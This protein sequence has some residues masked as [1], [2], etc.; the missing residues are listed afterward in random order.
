MKTSDGATPT[1]KDYLH[2]VGQIINS[3][4]MIDGRMFDLFDIVLGTTSEK[5]AV[6]FYRIGGF[7]QRLHLVDR[8]AEMS[9]S[10]KDYVTWSE[11]RINLAQPVITR[12]LVAHSPVR[13]THEAQATWLDLDDP[14]GYLIEPATYAISR[15]DKELLDPERQPDVRDLEQLNKHIDATVGQLQSLV[16][17]VFRLRP[18]P[19]APR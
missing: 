14:H 16:G 11:I 7:S 1:P 10:S 5:A 9:L 19:E 3:W 12:N 2:A 13:R 6:I 17:L 18:P 15:H 8:L 4:A